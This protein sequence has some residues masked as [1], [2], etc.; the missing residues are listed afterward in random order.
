MDQDPTSLS[1]VRI[2]AIDARIGSFRADP[3]PTA[4]F[5]AYCAYGESF[6]SLMHLLK[7]LVGAVV[8]VFVLFWLARKFE[9]MSD[10]SGAESNR[11][12]CDSILRNL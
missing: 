5:C 2:P 11:S 7:Y 8:A 10:T 6:L 4:G 12:I 3:A 1:H 9:W